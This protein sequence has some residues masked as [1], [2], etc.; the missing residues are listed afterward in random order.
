MDNELIGQKLESL[1]R[2]LQRIQEKCPP[3]AEML[4]S[5]LSVKS[6]HFLRRLVRLHIKI[7]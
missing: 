1:R 4:T 7:I 3:S 6:L 5:L 2:C